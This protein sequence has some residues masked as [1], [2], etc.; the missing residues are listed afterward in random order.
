LM[1]PLSSFGRG[2]RSQGRLAAPAQA[3]RAIQEVTQRFSADGLDVVPI[4][5]PND[6]L[7]LGGCDAGNIIYVFADGQTAVCPYL[8]FAARTPGSKH[9]D[10][11][12]LVGNILTDDVVAAL[13]AYDFHTRYR[14]GANAT[15]PSCALTATCG[16]GCPAAV[17]SR[18]ESIGAVDTEQ[19]PVPVIGPVPLALPVVRV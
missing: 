6:E 1:N 17:V 8:V 5:F 18:G 9:A 7:P 14:V 11:E 2:V 16:K 13:D 4:R 19:C 12:F 3:M 10:A 15:C